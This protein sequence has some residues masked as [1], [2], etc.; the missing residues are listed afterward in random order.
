MNTHLPVSRASCTATRRWKRC[1]ARPATPLES[2]HLSSLKRPPAPAADH[3]RRS[4][5]AA[6]IRA[7]AV[8][9]AG[10]YFA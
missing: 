5:R 10:S 6:L 4:D 3:V 9:A 8:T 2:E 7:K 1:T